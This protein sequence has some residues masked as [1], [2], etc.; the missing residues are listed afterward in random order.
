MPAYHKDPLVRRY[1]VQNGR[2]SLM[3]Y[4]YSGSSKVSWYASFQKQ[5]EWAVIRAKGIAPKMVLRTAGGISQG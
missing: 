4:V 5:T 3:V 1:T 2:G